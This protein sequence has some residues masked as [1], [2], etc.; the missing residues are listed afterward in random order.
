MGKS[1]AAPP[2]L[3]ALVKM[4]V[5]L[6]QRAEAEHPRRGRGRHPVMPDWV[7][8]TLIMVA[9]LRRKSKSGQYAF[10]KA[11][12]R[13]LQAW[14]GVSRF[15]DRSTY[16]DRYRR[17][18]RLFQAAIELQGKVAIAEGVAEARCVAV[19]RSLIR[20]A[21]PLWHMRQRKAGILPR[22]VDRDSTWTFSEYHGWLQ[23]YGYEVVVT[24]PCRGIAFP[25]L[26]SCDQAHVREQHTFPSKIER[27]PDTTINVLADGG[28]DSN[29][30]AEAVEWTELGRRRTGRRF[31]C[32]ARFH[33][34]PSRKWKST[35][36]RKFHR[37]LREQRDNRL[38]RTRE[39]RLYARRGRSVE[40]FN[41]RFKHLFELHDGAWIV[42]WTTT[43][44]RSWHEF[45][46]L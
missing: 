36:K 17:A 20:A 34:A 46:L 7:M 2:R 23:G 32:P 18:Y 35:R 33:R 28:Y 6:L 14:L 31:L 12:R 41:V 45:V 27:L 15:P 11:H 37:R 22:G 1:S 44:R 9:V 42:D 24:A 21:G 40:P 10:L 38:K 39:R 19:D 43:A 5:P 26:A 30:L 13:D 3:E 25:L 4:A 29:A 8:G 16:L